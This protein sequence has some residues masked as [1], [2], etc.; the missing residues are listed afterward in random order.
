MSFARPSALVCTALL[1]A[2]SSTDTEQSI[3]AYIDMPTVT[4]A[5]PAR[6]AI[7]QKAPDFTL[8]DQDGNMVSLSDFRG[9]PVVLEWFNPICPATRDAHINGP[10]QEMAEDCQNSGVVFL[11]INSSAEGKVGFGM[12]ESTA[13]R[14]QWNMSYPVLFDETGRVGRKYQAQRTPHMYVIDPNGFLVYRGALDNAP[15]GVVRSQDSE[16]RNY[17]R[18]ALDAVF[19]GE[20]VEQWKTRAYGCHVQYADVTEG[21]QGR[22]Q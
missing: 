6:A 1:F 19:A 22:D 16:Y 7:G 15:N 2:C 13:A 21:Q 14:A 10:I 5:N 4:V 3:S 12:D 18:E 11:A 17:V 20:D 8:M 9:F